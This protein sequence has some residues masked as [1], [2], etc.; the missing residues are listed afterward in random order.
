ME[1]VALLCAESAEAAWPSQGIH[2]PDW[3]TRMLA[4]SWAEPG[5]AGSLGSL[6]VG[7]SEGCLHFLPTWQH[8]EHPGGARDASL[9]GMIIIST[10]L[11]ELSGQRAQIPGKET[12]D[13][14][15]S[16]EK[17]GLFSYLCIYFCLLQL[18]AETLRLSVAAQSLLYSYGAGTP[19]CMGSVVE[20]HRLR[21][22]TWA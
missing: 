10:A 14:P 9:L 17:M 5:R 20:A 1:R 16:R 8:G 3:S 19:E 4:V 21:C 7:L 11:R 13:P 15:L 12:G 22:S 18:L 2:F 6:R